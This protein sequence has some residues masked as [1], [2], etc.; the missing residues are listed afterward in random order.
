MVKDV[1]DMEMEDIRSNAVS[2]S[3]DVRKD[4]DALS[5]VHTENEEGETKENKVSSSES[6]VVEQGVDTNGDVSKVMEAERKL[7]LDGKVVDEKAEDNGKVLCETSLDR[8]TLDDDATN[9]ENGLHVDRRNLLQ[10][11]GFAK[12]PT[13]PRSVRAHR[14]IVTETANRVFSGEASQ[15]AVN[16]V[17]E[18]KLL[19]NIQSDSRED[20]FHQENNGSSAACNETVAPMP[21]QEN[22]TSDVTE[23]MREDK[24]NAQLHL[25]QQHKEETDVSSLTT[26]QKDSFMQENDMS[27][28]TAS[29][30][31]VM[32]QETNLSMLTDTHEDSLIE[33]TNLS[34]KIK[35]QSHSLIE[36]TNLSP[37]IDVTDQHKDSF[38]KETDL[39]PKIKFQ[40]H[41]LIEETNLSPL[42]DVT[43]QHKDS[44]IKETDLS[45]LT[46]SHKVSLMQETALPPIMSSDEHNLNL[47]F[48]EGS[49]ICDIEILPQDVDL[50][51]L[52]HQRDIAGAELLSI[53][54]AEDIIKM[55]EEKL[56]QS[57]SFEIHN[58]PGLGQS[59]AQVSSA[60]P[61][62]LLQ[63]DFGAS[64][65][66]EM[67]PEL[68]QASLDSKAVQVIG[69]ED[70]TNIEVA[71]FDSS[72]AKNE[73]I[74]SSMDDLLHPGIHTDELPVI[75]DG[76]NFTL[77]DYLGDDIPCYTSMQP[78][79]QAGICSNDSEGI[80]SMDDSIYGSLTDIGFMD[81]WD[82]PAEDFAK[83]F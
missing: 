82:Q 53:V 79:L 35:F 4:A 34:P 47:Q 21:L 11:C 62:K 37:S 40:S 55:E 72:K 27:P 45:P 23:N 78:D 50:I 15:M 75:Q 30:E 43:D 56:D 64:K 67:N 5:A 10:H 46:A 17:G 14:N 60:D 44:F 6:E 83:F 39:S 49:Q 9:L 38:I 61:H 12:A 29:R 32:I 54:E 73:M 26:A 16:E 57:R 66:E 48:K 74:C 13:R 70:E 33:E 58:N 76:Y 41:S 31:D 63:G 19:T 36:E 1:V 22:R 18:E 59:S 8:I 80:A 65:L 25:V 7:L 42:I 2:S 51:E 28:L 20:E 69:I 68:C 3:D 81:V 71:G 24:N 77:S 52:S